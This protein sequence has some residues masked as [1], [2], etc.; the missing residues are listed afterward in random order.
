MTFGA[1]AP[2]FD[3]SS[4][5]S[6]HVPELDADAGVVDGS[7]P[8]EGAGGGANVCTGPV[9]GGVLVGFTAAY[10][11][12]I[13]DALLPIAARR[14]PSATSASASSRLGHVVIGRPPD[15]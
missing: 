4:E 10:W 12:E 11:P 5:G 14:I 8:E 2:R 3:G 6:G 9:E 15:G 1:H 13:A 7:H